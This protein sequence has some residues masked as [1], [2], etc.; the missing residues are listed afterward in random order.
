MK[1]IYLLAIAALL[2]SCGPSSKELKAMHEKDSL[3]SVIDNKDKEL[4]NMMGTFNE[5]QEGF[6]LINEA[7][8]RVNIM[9][10]NAE[11]NGAKAN[12]V[13]NM[14]FIQER[15]QENR[16]KIE[17]LQRRLNSSSFNAAKLK[18]AIANL[19]TQLEEKN[20]QL[21]EL[22]LQLSLKDQKITA[23]TDTVSTLMTEN[24][25]VKAARDQSEMIARNQDEQLNTAWYVYG[26]TKELKAHKI[27]AK[28]DVLKGEYDTNYLTK[29]DIRKTTVIPLNSKSAKILTT[30]PTGSYTLMK[31]NKKLYTL[32]ISDPAKF[33][34]VSKYLVVRIK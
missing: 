30:H 28:G 14:K 9:K 6:N 21:E 13:E 34:S 31:D 12:I 8:N 25:A 2:V 7:E 11:T 29:I 18:E 19:E 16:K 33:W 17:D 23:L 10:A 24:T 3:Q 5:I 32:R 4:N 15:L 26:T 1:K 27:L 22:Q 20:K